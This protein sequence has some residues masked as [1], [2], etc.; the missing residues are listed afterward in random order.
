[1]EVQQRQESGS[2]VQQNV[3]RNILPVTPE[4]ILK[5]S[6]LNE[7][8]IR[9]VMSADKQ[10]Q[11]EGPSGV[12]KMWSPVR[13]D[14]T[15]VDEYDKMFRE[16]FISAQQDADKLI[17]KNDDQFCAEFADEWLTL[18]PSFAT[19]FEDA[20]PSGCASPFIQKLAAGL[21]S[22]SEREINEGGSPSNS[23]ESRVDLLKSLSS[24]KNT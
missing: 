13:S 5:E 11:Y 16:H 1:M 2:P 4:Q 17:S 14:R 7:D 10:K 24:I 21:L 9:D 3:R 15:G 8:E 12:G 22:T 18:I 20:H 23:I 19:Y 6:G